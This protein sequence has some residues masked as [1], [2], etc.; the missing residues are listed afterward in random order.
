APRLALG[1]ESMRRHM[2]DEGWQLFAGLGRA[3]Y[4]L[5]G[6]DLPI[7]RTDVRELLDEYGPSVVV[8][9]DKREWEG[10]TAD[11][12][13]DPRMRFRRVNALMQRQ[14]VFTLTVLKD[15]HARPE[16]HRESAREIG[17]HAWVVYYHPRI[18]AHLAPYV[19]ER[20]LVRTYHTVD[21]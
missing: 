13:R 3:G 14:D 10:L 19:R 21:A 12:S 1:V 20:H 17:C 15:A 4:L 16:Y 7:N 5:C 18:V 11:R 8:L 9:Q 2:T 6:H